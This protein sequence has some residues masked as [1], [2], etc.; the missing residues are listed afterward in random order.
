[1][2]DDSIEPELLMRAVRKH[3]D[4]PWALFVHR[5]MAESP[6][7]DGGWEPHRARERDAAG[8]G[9]QRPLVS[10]STLR[11]FRAEAANQWRDAVT[12]A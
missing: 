9:H 7:A 12:V 8:R 11:I 5:Q 3:T 10:R 6:G 4:C 1:M 2:V